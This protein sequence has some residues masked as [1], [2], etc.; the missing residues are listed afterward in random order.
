MLLVREAKV[1]HL[2]SGSRQFTE[3]EIES[4][5]AMVV[6]AWMRKKEGE[7]ESPDLKGVDAMQ[8]YT[9]FVPTASSY[10]PVEGDLFVYVFLI[11][12]V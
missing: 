3:K 9:K 12:R 4:S 6:F 11:F 1:A 7:K 5:R 10:M 8:Q 2:Y